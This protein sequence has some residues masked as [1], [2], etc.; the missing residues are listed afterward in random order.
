M[1]RSFSILWQPV[2][3]R[4]QMARLSFNAVEDKGFFV[5][6]RPDLDIYARARTVWDL[7]RDIVDELDCLYW[8]VLTRHRS[9]LSDSDILIR[10]RLQDLIGLSVN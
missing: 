3:G 5:V 9:R 2:P 6:D 4:D 1:T 8:Q 7:K 10:D